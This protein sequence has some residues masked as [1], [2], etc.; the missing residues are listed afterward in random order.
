MDERG[1]GV[2]SEPVRGGLAELLAADWAL[3]AERSVDTSARW[4]RGDARE[5]R[6]ETDLRVGLLDVAEAGEAYRV[7]A[8][9]H[10]RLDPD[11]RQEKSAMN[12]EQDARPG[13][14]TGAPCS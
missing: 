8:A 4:N 2:L 5:R 7:A 11:G 10:V 14:R 12:E 13:E 6:D 9:E 1:D 3:K